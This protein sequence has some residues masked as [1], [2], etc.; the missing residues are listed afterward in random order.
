MPISNPFAPPNTFI[1]GL[2]FLREQA[3]PEIGPTHTASGVEKVVSPTMP[4]TGDRNMTWID[5]LEAKRQAMTL[6][7][8]EYT[9]GDILCIGRLVADFVPNS[10][11]AAGIV[12]LVNA[13]DRL[14]AVAK[15]AQVVCDLNETATEPEVTTAVDKLRLALEGK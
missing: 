11:N 6:G 13:A 10:S 8:W 4:P 3:H 2:A 5:E 12:A 15:S 14:I 1:C 7:K 9:D